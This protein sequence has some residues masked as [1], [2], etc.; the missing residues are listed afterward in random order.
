MG[1]Q[2]FAML[3]MQ[4]GSRKFHLIK[5]LC[6]NLMK[7]FPVD[8]RKLLG[9]DLPNQFCHVVGRGR[10]KGYII[11]QVTP[12]SSTALLYHYPFAG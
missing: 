2:L 7:T 6:S 5:K 8:L 11:S 1:L 3:E 10:F 9:L 12:K 4:A